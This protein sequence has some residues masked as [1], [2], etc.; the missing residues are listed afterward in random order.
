MPTVVVCQ[1]KELH[2]G[3]LVR[4]DEARAKGIAQIAEVDLH[5]PVLVVRALAIAFECCQCFADG[6]V[7]G[8]KFPAGDA[9][10]SGLREWAGGP[11]AI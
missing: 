1:H 9:K 3:K 8:A 4:S 10:E 11:P 7:I 6:L 2:V 5:G